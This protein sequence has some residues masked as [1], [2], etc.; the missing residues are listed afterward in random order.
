MDK[1]IKTIEVVT[2]NHNR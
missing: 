1:F 2:R